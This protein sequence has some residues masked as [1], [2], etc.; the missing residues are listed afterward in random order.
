MHH[1]TS[2]FIDDADAESFGLCSHSTL[3]FM[4][5]YVWKS[6][7]TICIR[8][9]ILTES[10]SSSSA[11]S[12]SSATSL[13][14]TACS[15]SS[16]S[17]SS[18]LSGSAGHMHVY[19]DPV[20]S[21]PYAIGQIGR[22]RLSVKPSASLPMTYDA[23]QQRDWMESQNQGTSIRRVDV[24]GVV[25][26]S[27][28]HTLILEREGFDFVGLRKEEDGRAIYRPIHLDFATLRIPPSLR[29]LVIECNQSL[30][31]LRLP[32]S[33]TSIK[34]GLRFHHRLGSLHPFPSALLTLYIAGDSIDVMGDDECAVWVHPCT[35]ATA[36]QPTHADIWTSQRSEDE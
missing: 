22:V 6:S 21:Y 27:S 9:P 5:S 10:A 20:L 23:S 30:D 18:S 8:L 31:G 1:L 4:K 15:S 29:S 14:D 19:D 12:S 28:M 25:L 17:S 11:S 13:S 7:H 2:N 26:P 16:S 32:D 34:T 33:C 3:Q 36:T 35:H 24:S